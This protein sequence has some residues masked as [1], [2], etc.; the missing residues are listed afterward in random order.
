VIEVRDQAI[1]RPPASDLVAAL[2]A[3]LDER[4][5]P[6]DFAP[7]PPERFAAPHGAF[8]VAYLD[9]DA[10][11]CGGLFRVDGATA[12]LKR[13]FVAPA[14]RG[15][16]VARAVLGALE[17]RAAGLG[18]ERL[19]LETGNR[20]PEAIALYRSAGYTDID[21][22]PPYAAGEVSVCFAKPLGD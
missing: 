6:G 19:R 9:G 4:Y 11:G 22:Y 2:L 17:E 15:R 18:Y 8:V 10:V 7:V 3:D 13:M 14:A 1:D 5:G 20:Q 12:E 21:P 16:G